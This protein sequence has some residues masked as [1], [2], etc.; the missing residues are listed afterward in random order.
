MGHSRGAVASGFI[1]TDFY[2]KHK[3]EAK[4]FAI[5]LVQFDPVPGLDNLIKQ[6]V[7][8]AACAFAKSV[9]LW[10]KIFDAVTVMAGYKGCEGIAKQID[11]SYKRYYY[12]VLPEEIDSTVV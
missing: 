5:E 8:Y 9:S 3:S 7:A 11:D 10:F 2:N 6:N 1:A 4:K 12:L